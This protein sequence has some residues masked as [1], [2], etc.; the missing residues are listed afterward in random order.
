MPGAH[1]DVQQQPDRASSR[2]WDVPRRD[3][4][5]DRSDVRLHQR[6]QRADEVLLDGGQ[7]R[8]RRRERSPAGAC[9]DWE[10]TGCCRDARSRR[11][12]HQCASPGWGRT[13]CSPDAA[14]PGEEPTDERP[15]HRWT[16]APRALPQRA[17]MVSQE[18]NLP[19]QRE[20]VQREP[21]QRE[22]VQREPVWLAL[23]PQVPE[24]LEQA[25]WPDQA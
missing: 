17:P 19:V 3:R 23:R 24:L 20:P 14:L 15:G 1:P 5:R 25:D 22:P 9:P 21:V 8:H 4:H 7:P 16:L 10:R 18:S 6:P 12:G 11:P 2:G 13:G